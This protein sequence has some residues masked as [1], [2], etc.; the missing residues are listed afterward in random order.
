MGDNL[1]GAI[2][3]G[4]LSSSNNNT[5]MTMIRSVCRNIFPEIVEVDNS[6]FESILYH[7]QIKSNTLL[8]VLSENDVI[9]SIIKF[10]K[11]GI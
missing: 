9:E 11:E 6:L 7:T 3:F 10:L 4:N 2:F 1:T 5:T 8:E